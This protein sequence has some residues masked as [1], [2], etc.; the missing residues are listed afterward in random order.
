MS[1]R[2]IVLDFDGVLHS[3]SSGWTGP[4]PIDPP[5][6]GA[7]DFVRALIGRGYHVVVQT[8]RCSAIW[9][10]KD[11]ANSKWALGIW[12]ATHG[13]PP[14]EVT[15]DKV[16]ALFYL[17]D[18]G[19]RFTGDFQEVLD[20]LLANP[21]GVPWSAPDDDLVDPS[22]EDVTPAPS[23]TASDGAGDDTFLCGPA[24]NCVSVEVVDL[25]TSETV[26]RGAAEERADIN[27]FWVALPAGT[28][29]VKFTYHNGGEYVRKFGV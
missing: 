28:Y 24:G 4:V 3:Y 11:R 1:N 5:V 10:E 12:L 29:I 7:V 20:F 18:R 8:A 23:E 21:R 25:A 26:H 9:P 6:E 15:G 14:L 17:D 16:P 19:W 2:T 22:R 13:F 27:G